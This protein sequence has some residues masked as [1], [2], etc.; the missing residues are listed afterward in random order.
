MLVALDT[1]PRAGGCWHGWEV[2]ASSAAS[3][4]SSSPA[5]PTRLLLIVRG[6]ELGL[7]PSAQPCGD[8]ARP[9]YEVWAGH[10]HT[11]PARTLPGDR[12]A[13]ED[14]T[15]FVVSSVVMLLVDLLLLPL[16]QVISLAEEKNILKKKKQPKPPNLSQKASL[17]LFYLLA[18]AQQLAGQ[19]VLI[20]PS[21][22][23]SSGGAAWL[24]SH[25]L[26]SE[27]PGFPLDST[28]N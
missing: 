8:L 21:N 25:A 7:L 28:V 24:G 6:R 17:R 11:S 26:D 15:H 18:S 16:G 3:R 20:S 1:V 2:A 4:C 9:R 5:P 23:S 19:R 14:K 13:P 10:W 12:A 22:S 27:E